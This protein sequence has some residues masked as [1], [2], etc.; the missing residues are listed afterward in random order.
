MRIT[1]Q[2]RRQNRRKFN[3]RVEKEGKT[4]IG[5]RLLDP[6]GKAELE[7]YRTSSD[8]LCIMPFCIAFEKEHDIG[9]YVF[10]CREG[11]ET[12]LDTDQ[13]KIIVL[14]TAPGVELPAPKQEMMKIGTRIFKKKAP[15]R[16]Y[17]FIEAEGTKE[18]ADIS[19]AIGFFLSRL[20]AAPEDEMPPKWLSEYVYMESK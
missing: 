11:A 6:R 4:L 5:R 16:T 2:Q 20:G 13:P 7:R 12:M 3:K 10:C 19:G 8:K 1:R 15:H 17:I 9:D 14:V 18:D